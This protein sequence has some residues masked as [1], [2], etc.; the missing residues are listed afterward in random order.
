MEA[1]TTADNL[2]LSATVQSTAMPSCFV[3]LTFNFWGPQLSI[4]KM[5]RTSPTSLASSSM[6]DVRKRGTLGTVRDVS[7]RC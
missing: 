2:E 6:G 3:N 5:D 4:Q 1:A 7:N